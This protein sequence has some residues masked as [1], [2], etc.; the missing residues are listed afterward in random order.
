MISGL[1]LALNV[2]G[3][4]V[5]LAI[6]VLSGFYTYRQRL[7]AYQL[8]RD[9][10]VLVYMVIVVLMLV[11]LARVLTGSPALLAV[12]PLLSFG[13]GFVE[14]TLLLSA[15][16][17][18]HLRPNGSTY[19]L[20]FKDL[21][22]RPAHLVLF[23]V[24]IGGT[25]AAELYLALFKPYTT[26][27]AQDFAGGTVEAV[28]YSTTFS[29]SIG[30]LFLLFLAYPVA[31][32]A[33]GALRVKNP[34]M[35]RAQF[36]LAIGWAGSSAIYLISSLSL[37]NY[38]LDV[39]AIAYVILSVFF[40]MI[41]R[42]FRKAALFAG[43]VLPVAPVVGQPRPGPTPEPLATDGHPVTFE[44]G[45]L[46]LLE[47]DTSGSYEERLNELVKGFLAEK[48]SVFVISAKG[49]RLH[50]FFST[51]PGVR[52][53]TMSEATRYI[54]PSTERSD[55]V[56]LPL[57]D[58]GVLLEVLD[59]TLASSGEHTAIIFDSISDMMIYL[60][61]QACYKFLKAAG[62]ITSGK[63]AVAL[64]LLF[65]GAH[66]DMETTSVRSVF[67]AQ[68]RVGPEGFEVVR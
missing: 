5:A 4:L 67:P 56:N 59:R 20:L 47:V 9:F 36:G 51:V 23:F 12:Y 45:Q 33:V 21:R 10:L 41:A 2:G 30:A 38:A 14:A 60:G 65:A 32:L 27:T 28:K 16:V 37:F 35:K 43:F 7:T 55:E 18:A 46:S 1:S 49:S 57:F 48:R 44:E 62:E 26:V 25:L 40:G 24:F 54:A 68:V 22:S 66:N 13:L 61:F 64:F 53:Y 31:L 29:I 6:T 39:T 17:G 3:Y 15:A 52:L 11:D 58:S 8:I 50:T 34:Q 19:G 42:N 63:K